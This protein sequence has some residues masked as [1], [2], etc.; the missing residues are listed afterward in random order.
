MPPRKSSPARERILSAAYELFY[1][2]GYQSTTVDQV[3]QVSGVSKPTVYTHF[4]T[5]E[6]LATAYLIERRRRELGAIRDR[7]RQESRP[8]KRFIS[9]AELV[10]ENL[11]SSD[12]RG[13][14][15]FNMVAELADPRNPILIE[16]KSFVDAYVDLIRDV[17]T[18]LQRSDPR[19][20]DLDVEKITQSYYLL[21]CGAIMA[22]QE[23]RQIWP[24]DRA[25]EEARRLIQS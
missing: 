9:I 6:A 14:G 19:Y 15:F 20:A 7:L 13:C 10:R 24:A 16:A 12:F 5:K 2:Q 18:D 1:H 4:P 21:I 22:C 3:I 23:F 25:I 11:R 17:T 8:E